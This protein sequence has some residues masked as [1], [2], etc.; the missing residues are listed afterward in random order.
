MRAEAWMHG[1]RVK[2]RGL[3][4]REA[5]ERE[6]DEELRYH[7][8]LRTEENIAKG[9]NPQEARR[10]ARIELGGVEQVKEQ[11]RAV[12]TGAWLETLLR[13]VRFV[14][15]RLR[16][17][18]GFTAVAVL[19]LALGIGATTAVFSVV[20]GV[21]L[22]PLPY[23]HPEELVYVSHTRSN[24]T[25]DMQSSPSN[26]FIYREQGRAFQDIGLYEDDSVSVTG[27]AEPEQISALDVTDGVLAILGVPPMLGRV[28]NS[29]DDSP[30]NPETV[31]LS[32]GF[33]RR[34][35]GGDPSAIGRTILIDGKVHE[36]IGVMPGKFR[37]LM[38]LQE[39]EIY[40]PLQLNRG[41]T[42]LGQFH[43]FSIARLKPGVTSAQANA[44]VA[45][46]L[47]IV[48]RG[49]P[50]PPGF[51]LRLFLDAHFAP[52]VK[53]LKEE[54]VGD[55]GS[56]LWV[57]MGGIGLVLLIACANVANLLL[58]R[59]EG[60]QH[61]LG[62]RAALG[63]SR[64][65]LAADLFLECLILAL[66]G[67]ALG[68]LMAYWALP[69]LIALAPSGLPRAS[70]IGIDAPVLLF[71][72]AVSLLVSLLAGAF[73]VSRHVRADLGTG[74]REAGRMASESHERHRARNTLVIA[75]VALAFILL[76]C[77]GLMIRTFRAL[78]RVQ[79]G[80]TDP[81]G[82]QTF[83]V[84]IP[85]AEVTGDEQV[86]RMEDEIQEKIQAIPGVTSVGFG[87]S[88]P[89]G[90][91][92][93]RDPVLVEDRPFSPAEMAISR[94]F[95]FISPGYVASLGTPLVAGR[96]FTWADIYNKIPVALVSENFA[97]TYWPD[98]ASALGKRIR[99]STTDDWREIIGVVGD[100]YQ[101]GVNKDAPP[102]AYWPV[103][104]Y[105]LES[106]A[107]WARRDVYFTV[108]SPRAGSASLRDDLLRAVGSADT[109]LLPTG[110]RTLDYFYRKSM[111]RTSFTLVMLGIA[112]GM[113][114]LLAIVG[115]SGVIAYSVSQ[116][117]REI[118]IRMALGAQ[119]SDLVRMFVRHGLALAGV[120][121]VCGLAAA[122]AVTR[123]MRSLLFHVSPSDPL[124]YLAVSFGLIATA[125][126]ASYI[127]SRRATKV[128]L[129]ETLR[130]G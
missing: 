126:L 11:V 103:L 33:W 51:P 104:A 48:F 101:D 9:M 34:K 109:H 67:S 118:G 36:I 121:V 120:G 15:R 130:G 117:R 40:L 44:D 110:M 114:L 106:N 113:A 92:H 74:L 84:H 76:V 19:T 1:L 43:Y 14:L 77:S 55:T 2:W 35:F 26:Y 68:L 78:I 52:D 65:R 75:Q 58:V 107:V 28:F 23:P 87:T 7:V 98:A 91:S 21:L 59:A 125:V 85:S 69:T 37:F 105:H 24:I 88:V 72:V 39:P 124:T 16:K 27:I 10:V 80:F 41:K 31:V 96:D 32:Y 20:E 45:R 25:G 100:V 47:P 97:R 8:E 127:P 17:S 5:V 56:V 12:R 22:K 122:A 111:A 42:I 66:L 53:P 70:E 79:P 128:D 63:A 6:L 119:Q 112:G 18:P 93:G 3:F 116:R 57:L 123:L 30:G 46:M 54:V 86:V 49:F 50:A 129:A 38:M 73:P 13:D 89:M 90:G 99:I 4:R 83:G 81:A 29:A 64:G 62:V 95:V 61:E 115:L 82:I 108:R 60:R 102:T 94:R 71:T